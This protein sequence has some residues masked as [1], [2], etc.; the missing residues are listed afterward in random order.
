MAGEK[1]SVTQGNWLAIE[2][3]SEVVR[4]LWGLGASMREVDI[5]PVTSE[6]RGPDERLVRVY[7]LIVDPLGEARMVFICHLHRYPPSTSW[8]PGSVFKEEGD[9]GGRELIMTYTTVRSSKKEPQ[10]VGRLRSL[11]DIF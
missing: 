8:M 2:M 1:I 3:V 10:S 7:S 5:E 4:R 6:E 11:P 9:S